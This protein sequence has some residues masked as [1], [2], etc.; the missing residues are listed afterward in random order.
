[1]RSLSRRE[2]LKTSLLFSSGL[3]AGGWASR[4]D[5][6]KEAKTSF[7]SG[8]IHVLA[9]GDFGTK[10]DKQLQVA[11]RMNEFAGK[12]GVPLSAVLALGD[13]FYG[14]L[15]PETFRSRF[16]DYYSTEHLDCPFHA[17][18]GNHDYGPS[19]DS[20]Q[21]RA[22]ADMQLAHAAGNPSSRWK[23]PAK[24]HAFEL[25]PRNNPLVKIIYLDG[26]YFEGALTPQEKIAQRRWLSA[27]MAKPTRARWLWLASH[28]P[29]FSDANEGR[30]KERANLLREWNDALSD[31]RVSLYLAGHDH[32]LQHLRAEG[33]G[34]DFIVSGGGGAGRH[35]VKESD[36]GFSM[37]TR[38]FSHIHVTGDKLT[39][40]YINTDGELIHSFERDRA[41]R[42]KVL[43]V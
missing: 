7:K 30:S 16:D 12:L 43:P 1:M 25:G 28:Y 42:T 24:W 21:G 8:G 4:L 9:F 22:K 19:Y 20:K 33:M 29:L 17:L 31:K 39:V 26:N 13:N 37:K 41:G 10:N 35:D 2:A 40:Q 5:A 15:T 11:R 3:L 14:H 34:P 6:A 23:M 36:R 38:G 32:T 27:E 18:L